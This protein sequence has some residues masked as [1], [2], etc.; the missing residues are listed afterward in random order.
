MT[1]R[2]SVIVA[3][4]Y[5]T[6]IAEAGDDS[7]LKA[8]RLS[9]KA[10][11][12]CLGKLSDKKVD[13]TYD[14]GKW[15]IRE[16]LQHIID[17]ERVFSFRAL[18]FARNEASPLPGFDQDSWAAKTNTRERSWD[19]MLKEFTSLRKSNELF[20]ASLSKEELLREGVA[21]GN[22]LNVVGIGFIC[23]GHLMHHL[24]IIEEKYLSAKKKS[25]KTKSTKKAGA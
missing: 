21:N 10:F 1:G 18:W 3:D 16:I 24:N 2:E 5:R 6:Y 25:A 22:P 9:T 4:F 23:A 15:T 13:W 17:T 12:Q 14:E 19:D 20:F 8:L 11:R 7:L